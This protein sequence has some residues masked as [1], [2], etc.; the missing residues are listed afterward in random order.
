M[1]GPRLAP[2]SAVLL[3]LGLHACREQKVSDGAAPASSFSA[4]TSDAA[5]P[6][7]SRSVSTAASFDLVALPDGAALAVGEKG[8]GLVV[9]LLDRR[10]VQRS[11]PVTL[12]EVTRERV[13]EVSLASVGSRLLLSW[14]A[15][16]PGGEAATFAALGDAATRSFAPPLA[17]G[18]VTLEP[19][20]ESGYVRAA[21]A[22]QGE[23]LVL[24][25]GA[26]EP[27]VADP[28]QRCAAF[29]FRELG[30]TADPRG[31]PMSVPAAC[32][33]GLAGFVAVEDRWHY[34]FCS[35]A[36]GR[37]V[38]THFMR[39]LRPFYVEVHRS[40][41]GCAPLDATV[42]GKDA[43]FVADCPT[44]R[45]AERVGA[46]REKASDIDLSRIDVVC[47]AGRPVF[48]DPERRFELELGGARD[49]LGALLP[50]RL[51]KGNARAAWTGSH[52]L[53]A[54]ATG[55]SVSVRSY[56]CRGSLLLGP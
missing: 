29:G 7:I 16:L 38:T 36:E 43:L 9:L 11:A 55:G 23:F 21:G 27:C 48:R 25:R 3:A 22:P 41:E 31:L 15:H 49:G 26:D 52:L 1:L 56:S 34:G 12:P 28:K 50:R 37:P 40:F 10:G 46:M 18:P 2:C 51:G 4:S 24:R 30:A 45:R 39:Q 42:V 14:V 19:G 35:Q 44:G 47:E 13:G 6:T 17:L 32:A 54:T 53:T 20:A 5:A 8:G 33:Q